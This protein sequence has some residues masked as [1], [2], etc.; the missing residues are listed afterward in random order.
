MAVAPRG[1][2]RCGAGRSR[3]L[4]GLAFCDLAG[5]DCNGVRGQGAGPVG[6]S[7]PGDDVFVFRVPRQQQHLDQCTGAGGLAVRGAGSGPPLVV[8]R[9]EAAG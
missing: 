7:Q 6:G 8:D 9:G 3:C 4:V 1:A 5:F 2:V